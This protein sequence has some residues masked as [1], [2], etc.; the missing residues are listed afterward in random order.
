MGMVPT[1]IVG[2]FRCPR[3]ARGKTE[4]LWRFGAISGPGPAR[5]GD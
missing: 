1:L 4:R 3:E 2:P 5:R